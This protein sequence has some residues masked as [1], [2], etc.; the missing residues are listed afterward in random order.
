L[1]R[2]SPGIILLGF[3]GILTGLA[4]IYGLKKSYETKPKVAAQPKAT[5]V[6]LASS[7]LPSGRALKNSDFYT[8]NL[9]PEQLAKKK[10]PSLMMAD[11]RQIVGRILR[12]SVSKGM[13][14]SP[15]I[16]YPEGTEPDITEKLR[17]GF[18]A[19]PIEVPVVG[20]PS[21]ITPGHWVDVLFRSKPTKEET[22]PEVTKTLVES[23]QVL[24]VGENAAEGVYKP[25]NAK[26]DNVVIML[27]VTADQSR[28]L[29]V[30][31][32]HGTFSLVLCS[33]PVEPDGI[34]GIEST[35][36][37]NLTLAEV[38]D[39]PPAP[40]PIVPALPPEPTKTEVFRRGRRQVLT[41]TPDGT[42]DLQSPAIPS[43]GT[44]PTPSPAKG[45]RWNGV[46]PIAPRDHSSDDVSK[47]LDDRSPVGSLPA[48]SYDDLDSDFEADDRHL[49]ETSR[50]RRPPDDT[51]R[52]GWYQA[53]YRQR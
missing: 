12:N 41:F 2:L 38:L 35:G 31:E 50:T 9:T 7:D 20:I 4:V 29:K 30:V 17:P 24:A 23:A 37:K 13:P 8:V 10:W 19:M 39:F 48:A 52:R 46:D 27:A 6:I 47:S 49:D 3:F 14:F 18:R 21:A 5:S 40:E 53:F 43:P 15:D 42:R 1:N 25:I 34:A 33:A 36:P 28:M 26:L 11:G 16:F 32:G 45:T 51:S 44:L 22:F